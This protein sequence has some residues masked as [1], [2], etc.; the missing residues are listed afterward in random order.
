MLALY[1]AA[2][3]SPEDATTI[4]KCSW[5]WKQ[6]ASEI[7]RAILQLQINILPSCITLV[8]FIYI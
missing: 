3:H 6:K 4:S 2:C 7:C 8:L 5:R 1:L